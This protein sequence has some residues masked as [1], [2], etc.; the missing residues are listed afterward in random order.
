MDRLNHWKLWQIKVDGSRN[1]F[2]SGL[3]E[4]FSESPLFLTSS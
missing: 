3:S 2:G 4:G 1:H